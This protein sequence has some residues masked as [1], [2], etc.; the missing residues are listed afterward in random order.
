MHTEALLLT[1]AL[2]M[3]TSAAAIDA[4]PS[5]E[6]VLADAGRSLLF[7]DGLGTCTS[8]P[9]HEPWSALNR[10][11]QYAPYPPQQEIAI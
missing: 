9:S 5:D 7:S 1:A 10:S 4:A 2:V 11:Q 3:S 8:T 6:L